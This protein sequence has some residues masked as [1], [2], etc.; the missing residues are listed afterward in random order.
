MNTD[1][2]ILKKVFV[3]GDYSES[4]QK[5]TLKNALRIY[6]K[7]PNQE[8]D[9]DSNVGIVVGRVQSGKTANIITLSALALDNGHKLVVLF[10]SDTNNLLDQNAARIMNS[11]DNIKGV[12]VVKKS[13]NGDFDTVLDVTTLNHL[14]KKNTK[15]VVC[16]LKHAKHIKAINDLISQSPYKED[17]A[18]IIDDEGDDIGL[19]TKRKD[20][21]FVEDENGELIEEGRTA[22]NKSIVG[23]KTTMNKLGYISLTATPEANILLQDFQQLAPDYCVTLEPNKGYTG[24]QTFHSEESDR[25]VEVKDYYNLL[26]DNGIPRSLDDAFK[27]FLAGCL[28]REKREGDNDFKHSMMIHPDH[29]IDNH[30]IVSIK[31]QDYIDKVKYNI[32]KKNQSGIRYANDVANYYNTF[33]KDGDFKL[34]SLQEVFEALKIHVVNSTSESNDLKL[35]MKYL[36]YHIVIGG[37]MLDRGIT[38]DG[39]AVTY[40]IRMSKVGQVDTLLQRARWFGYKESYIDLCRVYLPTELKQQ[41]YDLIETEESVWQ[42]LYE[43]DNRNLSPKNEII[44]LHV[45]KTLRI[46]STAKASY[47]MENLASFVKYQYTIVHNNK[48]NE[49]NISLVDTIDWSKSEIVEFNETQKHRKITISGTSFLKFISNFHFSEVEA[50]LSGSYIHSLM[51]KLNPQNIDVWDMRFEIKEKR[52]SIDYDIK[53]LLQGRSENKSPDDEGYYCGD[54]YLKTNNL[55]LQI[56]HVILKN[57]IEDQY[58]AGNEVIMLAIVL[59]D[60]YV[61]CSSARRMTSIEIMNSKNKKSRRS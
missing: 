34:D 30:E 48:Y 21:K 50:S 2:P 7:L 58:S 19:N 49:E 14:Y 12:E 60:G 42:F 1:G 46:A 6:N 20:L 24:L 13:K 38:I 56:H 33:I 10:L 47:V 4:Q 17:Y 57:D 40:M 54:R 16:S 9:I 23:L 11:F 52:S 44:N 32:Q 43:C 28:V 35:A 45:P 61:G 26:E 39:L 3:N 27:F 53:A 15:L 37:N 22:T 29:R 36:P 25:V 51:K 59:P 55:S 18:L 5:S 31:I 41:F 8:N